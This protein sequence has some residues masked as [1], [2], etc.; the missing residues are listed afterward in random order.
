[1]NTLR[2]QPAA[3]RGIFPGISGRLPT[4]R[5]SPPGTRCPERRQPDLF[6]RRDFCTI[7]APFLHQEMQFQE[8]CSRRAPKRGDKRCQK[9]PN[10]AKS[11]HPI[12]GHRSPLPAPRAFRIPPSNCFPARA[13]RGTT[14]HDKIRQKATN[15]DMGTSLVAAD[16]SPRH[17]NW[18]NQAARLTIRPSLALSSPS[19][20][21]PGPFR[22]ALHPK[23]Y[24]A[25]K[26]FGKEKVKFCTSHQPLTSTR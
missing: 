23:L 13:Q 24:R 8:L 6:G 19:R 16:V 20:N 1:V 12:T 10:C 9:V 22:R 25:K 7:C 3:P 4:W 26:N 15:H 18:R 11:C 14:K 5:P 2:D 17:L 21:R